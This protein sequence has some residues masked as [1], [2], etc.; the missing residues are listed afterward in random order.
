MDLR[1]TTHRI[2]SRISPDELDN[3]GVA[4]GGRDEKLRLQAC[5]ALAAVSRVLL[6]TRYV[7]HCIPSSAF[8][9]RSVTRVSTLE[10]LVREPVMDYAKWW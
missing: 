1:P 9:S 6:G 2:L 4:G 5:A 8:N 7:I 3:G 10:N